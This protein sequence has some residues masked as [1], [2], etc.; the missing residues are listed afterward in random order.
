MGQC[1]LIRLTD[2]TRIGQ[3]LAQFRQMIGMSRRQCAREIAHR[4]GRTE[5]SVNAQLWTWDVGTRR[6]ELTSLVV[7]LQVLGVNLMLD[8][9]PEEEEI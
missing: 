3:E 5:T 9:E 8:F 6:P 4:T 7:Y 2:P 1:P